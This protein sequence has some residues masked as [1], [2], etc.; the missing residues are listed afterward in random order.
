MW[1][2][3]CYVA[4]SGK[5]EVQARYSSGTDDLKAGL[6]V[7]LDYLRVR[8]RSEWRRPHAA[9]MS[10]CLEFRDFFEIRFFSER[11]QQR[12]IGYFGP[13]NNE[14]TLLL[15]AVEK[16]GK[17]LPENWCSKA[18]DRR[19]QIINGDAKVAELKLDGEENAEDAD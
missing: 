5:N 16:G 2:I 11:L 19:N 9:K 13:K 18:N 15:W 3:N 6:E 17:F 10:K 8:E 1:K 12:P 4:P 7:E 14:F